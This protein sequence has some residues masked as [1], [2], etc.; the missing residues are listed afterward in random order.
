MTEVTECPQC[1]KKGLVK[2]NADLFQCLCCE[3]KRDFNE[4]KVS[5]T[6]NDGLVLV[7]LAIVGLLVLLLQGCA[8]SP[9]PRT[10]VLPPE[11]SDVP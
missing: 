9:S 8:I 1:G 7:M 3:F 11:V 5:S 6:S 2:R 4:H 10:A